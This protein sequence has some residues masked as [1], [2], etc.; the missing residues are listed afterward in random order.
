LRWNGLAL[1]ALA[2]L[3][4]V[5]FLGPNRVMV[6]AAESL[7]QVPTRTWC[8]HTNWNANAVIK[9][10]V[11]ARL[12]S[13]PVSLATLVHRANALPVPMIALATELAARTGTLLTI[14]LLLKL[15]KSLTTQLTGPRS[16]GRTTMPRTTALGTLTCTGVACATTATVVQVAPWLSALRQRTPLMT[17]AMKASPQS[18]TTSCNTT[19]PLAAQAGSK[20]TRKDRANPCPTKS[21]KRWKTVTSIQGTCLTQMA[22]RFTVATAPFPDKTALVAVS[23]TTL[24]VHASVSVVTLVLLAK[25][26]KRWPK[27]VVTL[28]ILT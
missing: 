21:R 23:A 6:S 26:W 19:H 2:V 28:L 16:S 10:S 17:N 20:P 3:A 7:F 5:V 8:A 4:L 1:T 24:V 18:Q 27:L 12:D 13:A 25:R 11:I 14:G 9:D 22:A 15:D